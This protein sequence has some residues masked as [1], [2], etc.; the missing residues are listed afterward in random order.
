MEGGR[1]VC[2]AHKPY[3]FLRLSLSL[4]LHVSCS[5]FPE[6]RD[7]AIF[8]MCAS[9]KAT[10]SI[11]CLTGKLSFL[12]RLQKGKA[13]RHNLIGSHVQGCTHHHSFR[14]DVQFWALW[15]LCGFGGSM[16]NFEPGAPRHSESHSMYMRLRVCPLT[17]HKKCQER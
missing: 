9:C 15:V 1:G 8:G 7:S 10:P 14:A 6:L 11:C 17:Y 2:F 13:K 5:P 4:S 3:P 16:L 12:L